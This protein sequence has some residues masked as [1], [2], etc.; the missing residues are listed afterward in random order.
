M[1]SHNIRNATTPVSAP[2]ST[3]VSASTNPAPS[4][5]V[6]ITMGSDSDRTVLMPGASLLRDFGIP[7]EVDITSA[8]RT[9]DRMTDFAKTAASRG[10]KVIIAAAG[11]AA[12]LPG[13]I[14][15][16]STLPVI[17]VPVKASRL[18]GLDSLLSI[19]Q[20][21]VSSPFDCLKTCVDVSL[22][23]F[24][25]RGCPVAT[26]AIDNSLNAAQ[27]AIRI[28]ALE[29]KALR[30]KLEKYLSDQTR[31]VIE[32]AERMRRDGIEAYQM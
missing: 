17:G 6:A 25:Q 30:E 3:S 28:L 1:E 12:H 2:A 9:P 11:G 31:S 29:D 7:F 5:L 23:R 15:A 14:A 18:D 16:N 21:P 8:H 26:V 19:V 24:E 13:M 32:K 20:M 22:I 4:P 27:L 10:I